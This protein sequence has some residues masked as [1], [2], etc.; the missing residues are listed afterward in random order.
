VPTG[1]KPG[2]IDG[3]LERPSICIAIR[4]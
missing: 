3:A 1:D 4:L 2:R